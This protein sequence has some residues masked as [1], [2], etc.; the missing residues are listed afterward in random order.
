MRYTLT[1]CPELGMFRLQDP[2]GGDKLLKPAEL[3]TSIGDNVVLGQWVEFA[4]GHPNIK[5]DYEILPK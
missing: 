5:C 4:K 3:A 2:F 1:W